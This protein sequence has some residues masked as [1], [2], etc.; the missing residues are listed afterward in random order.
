MD[1][2]SN[3]EILLEDNLCD[4]KWHQLNMKIMQDTTYAKVDVGTPF[5]A[6]TKRKLLLNEA[7]VIGGTG[8]Q[9]IN[10]TVSRRNFHGCV[11]Y[12]VLNGLDVLQ[13][14]SK[15]NNGLQL[16]CEGDINFDAISYESREA[17]VS[18]SNPIASALDIGLQ[19]RTY[20]QDGLLITNE[21]SNRSTAKSDS[22]NI[23]GFTLYFEKN[24]VKLRVNGRTITSIKPNE[25]IDFGSW[26]AVRLRMSR[27]LAKLTVGQQTSVLE[28]KHTEPSISYRDEIFIGKGTHIANAFR[29]WIWDINLNNNRLSYLNATRKNAVIINYYRMKDYCYPNHC[30]NGGRCIQTY[31]GPRCNCSGTGF[32][33]ATCSKRIKAY[34]KTCYD[35]YASGEREN[36][37]YFIEPRLK[38]MKVYCKMDD[39]RGP[40][41]IVRIKQGNKLKAVYEALSSDNDF[42]YHAFDYL[43]EKDQVDDLIRVSGYCRQY[44]EY[45]CSSST[46]MFSNDEENAL[47]NRYGARWFSNIGNIKHYWGGGDRKAFTCACGLK[48]NCADPRLKCNCDVM[49]KQWRSD[50]GYLDDKNDLPVSKLQF[51]RKYTNPRAMYKLGP[52]ECFTDDAKATTTRIPTRT[53][54]ADVTKR[55]RT[56]STRLTSTST[57]ITQQS[58]ISSVIS[59]TESTETKMKGIVTSKSS[60]KVPRTSQIRTNLSTAMNSNLTDSLQGETATATTNSSIEQETRSLSANVTIPL[61]TITR[62]TSVSLLSNG[63][64]RHTSPAINSKQMIILIVLITGLALL[65]LLLIVAVMRHRIF[66]SNNKLTVELKKDS[67]I[68]SNCSEKD[69]F[70][71]RPLSEDGKLYRS[72][73]DINRIEVIRVAGPY[74]KSTASE[75]VSSVSSFDTSRYLEVGEES[76]TGSAASFTKRKG[77]L[78]C[79]NRFVVS[80]RPKSEGD[81]DDPEEVIGLIHINTKT[82]TSKSADITS[83]SSKSSEGLENAKLHLHPN[84]A[85]CNSKM[86]NYSDSYS[87][88]YSDKESIDAE[89][90]FITDS[91]SSYDSRKSLSS[92]GSEE[93]TDELYFK[94]IRRPKRSV[95]FSIKELSPKKE[96]LSLEDICDRRLHAD[97]ND[98]VFT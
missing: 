65:T 19:F 39:E 50:G 68:G 27:K 80:S 24:V 37:L 54:T 91:S 72:V 69:S 51:S 44:I 52:L 7:I 58:W 77:I 97:A 42:Y 41:T 15:Q 85:N 57:K 29:G 87:E 34:K 21:I 73:S 76:D 84:D 45:Y 13:Q 47:A 28:I 11:S 32:G 95:R 90:G 26:H 86:I 30:E 98:D 64:S 36:G 6:K 89:T 55:S 79:N 31:G 2:T 96:A 46:L 92:S 17:F 49:D 10:Q 33:G 20:F 82:S 93:S 63:L 48:G 22:E 53:A 5:N 81:I 8:K 14:V 78:K 12:I 83:L 62:S 1:P 40:K 67:E 60:S 23:M 70:I 71:D 56:E 88:K 94:K 75:S 4:N 61:G 74:R 16:G 9:N 38:A 25:D 59:M 66:K 35:Y 18:F 43:A 3:V